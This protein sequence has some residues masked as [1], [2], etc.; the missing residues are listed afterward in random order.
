MRIPIDPV[1]SPVD[2]FIPGLSVDA[3]TGGAGAHIGL[4]YYYY[5]QTG[6]TFTS[7]ALTTGFVASMDGGASWSVPR[8]RGPDATRG[9]IAATN[10]GSMVGDYTATTF[11]AGQPLG[12]FAIGLP[13]S[14]SLLNEAM[15][16]AQRS[17]ASAGPRRR[18]QRER[19]IPGLVPDHP[20][21]PR[22]EFDGARDWLGFGA[23]SEERA[24]FHSSGKKVSRACL[25]GI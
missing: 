19:P 12:I 14:P 22:P 3:A 9:W 16:A 24:D 7:C 17:L 18:V 11:G 21:R 6:C 8:A 4:T 23:G 5:P 10:Q 1:T 15:Y 2:H 25:R 20:V 13:R